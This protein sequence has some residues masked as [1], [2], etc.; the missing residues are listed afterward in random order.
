MNQDN[1][2]QSMSTMPEFKPEMP[3]SEPL[4]GGR[5]K[6]LISYDSVGYRPFYLSETEKLVCEILVETNSYRQVQRVVKE[7]F[8]RNIGIETIKRWLSTR[9]LVKE[10]MMKL[11]EERGKGMTEGEWEAEVA[12]AARKNKKLE[13]TTPLMYKLYAEKKGWL[14]EN[15]GSNQFIGKD[16]T[17][18]I[19]QKN[20]RV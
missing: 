4:Q 7:R 3:V 5:V 18:N 12:E 11:M 9:P 15:S 2:S 13:R 14:R 20:G 16:I 8:K 10:Y 19:L 17:V 1:A 6:E